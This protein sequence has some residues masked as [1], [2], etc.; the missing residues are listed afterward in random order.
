MEINTDTHTHIYIHIIYT[1]M[2]VCN[3]AFKVFHKYFKV[4]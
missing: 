2:W 3:C 4:Y 1:K